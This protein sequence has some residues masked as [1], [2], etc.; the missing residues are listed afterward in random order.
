MDH[1]KLLLYQD[2]HYPEPQLVKHSLYDVAVGDNMAITVDKNPVP[3]PTNFRA[4]GSDLDA[5][6]GVPTF[7]Q[8]L[9]YINITVRSAFIFLAQRLFV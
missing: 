1:Q 7:W 3:V 4:G 5:D 8:F 2:C 9:R 6:F